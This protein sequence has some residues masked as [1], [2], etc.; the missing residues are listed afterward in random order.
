MDDMARYPGLVRRKARWYLRSRV[1]ADLTAFLK[2]AEVWRSLGTVEYPQ[3]LRRYTSARLT[4][5][6]WFDQQR[7]RRDA[8]EKLNGQ[9]PVLVAGWFH[10]QERR[11]APLDFDLS[12][13]D[14]LDALAETEAV[15][16]D[17]LAGEAGAEVQSAIDE[18]LINAGWPGRPHV[19]GSISTKRVKVADAPEEHRAALADLIRRALVE[20]A[21][22]RRDRLQGIPARPVDQ[23]FNGAVVQPVANGHD[24]AD[25][26]L[27]VADLID[28]F[29]REK[30]VRIGFSKR[31]EYNL[32]FKAL[33]EVWGDH[34]PA[35]SITRADCREIR[36]LFASLPPNSTKRWPGKTLR[37]AAQHAQANNVAPLNPRT[38]NGYIRRMTRMLRWAT[39]EEYIDRNPA[40]E[41]AVAAPEV[42]PRDARDPFSIEHL[43]RIFAASPFVPRDDR[44]ATFWA[45]LIS[46]YGGLRLSEITGLGTADVTTMDGT[47]VILIK[48]DPENGR[49]LK[50]PA[51]RRIVP[52]HPEL[53]KIGFLR[54]VTIRRTAG[55]D[56]LFDLQFDRRG[57]RTNAI[58]KT[59]ARQ[60]ARAGAK[61]PRTSFH[62]LRHNF[63]DG[64]READVSRDAVLALGGWSTGGTEEDYGKGL[65]PS[66]LARELAKVRYDLDL[67]HLHI[68]PQPRLM[69]RTRRRFPDMTPEEI[70]SFIESNAWRFAKTMAHMPHSYVVKEKCRDPREFERFVMHIRRHG[71]R[72][73]FG[74]AY[75]TYLDHPVDGV[76]HQ[77]WTMGEPLDQT[78]I[79]NR[80][81]KK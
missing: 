24:R 62:S 78:I 27:T 47:D 71:Y 20:A 31:T 33:R 55:K 59:L 63:R 1:P 2:R 80:A 38:A 64:L 9:A 25:A 67:S 53:T 46:L 60:I 58:Q 36:D 10:E 76:V 23:L 28:R 48:P 61:A 6:R 22:L 15:L 39:K 49:R 45:P 4:L 72:Q 75:Y 11:T 43:K 40:E 17:L 65:R 79:I 21:R 29:T 51:A 14:L 19:V 54:Y 70:G 56:F 16:A 73:R 66:T 8:G 74:R 18:V 3:A 57:Y 7:A 13:D 44:G 32:L 68:E 50:T 30:V 5:Q 41:L 69:V 42:D 52:V 35:R 34:R 26:G 77:F 37:Q 81:V 12:G